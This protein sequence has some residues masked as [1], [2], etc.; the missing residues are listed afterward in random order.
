MS[1]RISFE[2]ELNE[3]QRT[4][5]DWQGE[6]LDL[7]VPNKDVNKDYERTVQQRK[8]AIRF[9][10]FST[11]LALIILKELPL[12]NS[13]KTIKPTT[14]SG[15]AGGEKFV[16]C[17][18]FFKLSR[19]WKNLYGGDSYAIK[20]ASHELK[21]AMAY[22]DCRIVGLHL[23]LIALIKFRGHAI[24]AQTLCPIGK[25]TIRYGSCD[26]VWTIHTDNPDLNQKME[27]A[28][29][30]INIKGHEV[31]SRGNGEFYFLHAPADVEGH[32]GTDGRFYLVDTAR[33]FPPAATKKGLP[34][35]K[36]SHLYQCLRPELVKLNPVPLSSDAF[37]KW[38]ASSSDQKLHNMEVKDATRR[39]EE[40]IIPAF[41]SYLD[42]EMWK[43]QHDRHHISNFLDQK[44]DISDNFL[45]QNNWK[46]SQLLLPNDHD[47]TPESTVAAPPMQMVQIVSDMHLHG[48]NTRYLGYLYT[49]L[50]VNEEMK[51]LVLTEA[52][53]R[54]LKHEMEERWRNINSL[55]DDDYTQALM[56]Y[57]T[58]V[59]G[60]SSDANQYWNSVVKQSLMVRFNP[61]AEFCS[62]NGQA[63]GANCSNSNNGANN[64]NANGPR[65]RRRSRPLHSENDPITKFLETLCQRLNIT[66]GSH[67]AEEF[68]NKCRHTIGTLCT[69][70]SHLR[71]LVNS[72]YWKAKRFYDDDGNNEFVK[73]LIE[74]MLNEH[75]GSGGVVIDLFARNENVISLGHEKFVIKNNI[76]LE[77]CYK[78]L[79]VLLKV[80]EENSE[81]P[82]HSLSGT[83][84]MYNAASIYDKD[85]LSTASGYFFQPLRVQNIK[86]IHPSVKHIHKISFEEGYA[87]NRLAM[88][89]TGKESKKIFQMARKKFEECLDIKENDHV[90]LYCLAFSFSQLALHSK[91]PKRDEFWTLSFEKYARLLV[92]QPNDVHALTEFG[93]SL[94]LCAQLTTDPE[95]KVRLAEKSCQKFELA[96]QLQPNFYRICFNAGNAYALYSK[97]INNEGDGA[98]VE[99]LLN[100]AIKFYEI[101]CDLAPDA[102]Q[103]LSNLALSLGRLAVATIDK[104]AQDVL[105][106]RSYVYFR[107]TITT[108]DSLKARMIWGHYQFRHAQLTKNSAKADSLFYSAAQKFHRVVIKT[109]DFQEERVLSKEY[110]IWS[111]SLSSLGKILEMCLKAPPDLSQESIVARGK[112]VFSF[113][114]FFLKIIK[115][116]YIENSI[117][118]PT[119]LAQVV[120]QF[121]INK[122][123]SFTSLALSVFQSISSKTNSRLLHGSSDKTVETFSQVLENPTHVPP[124]TNSDKSLSLINTREH[125]VMDWTSELLLQQRSDRDLAEK[126]IGA[127]STRE[128]FK[129][130]VK[131]TVTKTA[132]SSSLR[133]HHGAGIRRENSK[134]GKSDKKDKIH[135]ENEDK[136]TEEKR[137]KEAKNAAKLAKK[138][139]KER[140]KEERERER[141]SAQSEK[142]L[143]GHHYKTNEGRLEGRVTLVADAGIPS[144]DGKMQRRKSQQEL[145][146]SD[147][148]LEKKNSKNI[149]FDHLTR[150][151]LKA[152]L[153][154]PL[155]DEIEDAR[156][157]NFWVR[158][159]EKKDMADLPVNKTVKRASDNRPPQG[160]STGAA[161]SYALGTAT[162]SERVGSSNFGRA[163]E[164]HE[165]EN[166]HAHHVSNAMNAS[167]H[168]NSLPHMFY[169]PT[170]TSGS[171]ATH[172]LPSHSSGHHLSLSSAKT[173]TKESKDS[174]KQ[175]KIY[176]QEKDEPP[177]TSKSKKNAFR[178]RKTHSLNSMPDNVMN[179][180]KKDL[181]QAEQQKENRTLV[182]K[183]S[184]KLFA[185][186]EKNKQAE[187][188]LTT[189]ASNLDKHNKEKFSDK[190]KKIEQKKAIRK[191]I[192]LGPQRQSKP[193]EAQFVQI[194]YSFDEAKVEPNNFSLTG[195]MRNSGTDV[196]F[197]GERTEMQPTNCVIRLTNLHASASSSRSP[198]KSEYLNLHHPFLYKCMYVLSDEH[199]LYQIYEFRRGVGFYEYFLKV[200]GFKPYTSGNYHFSGSQ[201]SSST[202]QAPPNSKTPTA[203]KPNAAD[204]GGK[205]SSD[206]NA[207]P[208]QG[209]NSPAKSGGSD[210]RLSKGGNENEEMAGNS[211]PHTERELGGDSKTATT[212][213]CEVPVTA[214]I[215]TTIASASIPSQTASTGIAGVSANS[216]STTT[217]TTATNL[218]AALVSVNLNA[219]LTSNILNAPP[220]PN[221]PT[222]LSSRHSTRITAL[223]LPKS[224]SSERKIGFHAKL[225]KTAKPTH[226]SHSANAAMTLTNE[227]S[228]PN[229][230]PPRYVG[231]G[232]MDRPYLI[233]PDYGKSDGIDGLTDPGASGAWMSEKDDRP[234]DS[235]IGVHSIP[236]IM[237]NNVYPD[238]SGSLLGEC[239]DE[240]HSGDGLS[241]GSGMSSPHSL[242][243]ASNSRQALHRNRFPSRDTHEGN[244]GNEVGM[245]DRP[246]KVEYLKDPSTTSDRMNKLRSFSLS[247]DMTSK[248]D[249]ELDSDRA[250]TTHVQT[251]QSESDRKRSMM[252]KI[253]EQIY[254]Y[255]AQ[256]RFYFVEA[257]FLI[258]YLQ[259]TNFILQD[260]DPR[261]ILLTESGHLCWD[262]PFVNQTNLSP[263]VLYSNTD[264][265]FLPPEVMYPEKIIEKNVSID[266]TILWWNFSVFFFY[267]FYGKFPYS[268]AKNHFVFNYSKWPS[269]MSVMCSEFFQKMFALDVKHRFYSIAQLQTLPFF[270]NVDW[271]NVQISIK[272]GLVEKVFGSTV[273]SQREIDGY[274]ESFHTVEPDYIINNMSMSYAEISTDYFFDITGN[275]DSLQ[276]TVSSGLHTSHL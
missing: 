153:T 225:D 53:A 10:E 32:E 161:V 162:G 47:S 69:T 63:G 266:K 166:L 227:N 261:S 58:F 71:V 177:V 94:Y 165:K 173:D 200:Q 90:A 11:R 254:P 93:S 130:P 260:F 45:H 248:K 18:I 16:C 101:A 78:R 183:L 219:A 269:N 145:R 141:E 275:P 57:V 96:S 89:K 226:L 55:N 102:C 95:E 50:K 195:V 3:L 77:L 56:D 98:Q 215:S 147:A 212:V 4:Q 151:D 222:S 271:Q 238:T 137:D 82:E 41:A 129:E 202:Q 35:S 156:T 214:S 36:G 264:E 149:Q 73:A 60:D 26:Q 262:V 111:Q 168:T 259:S 24:L 39:L 123:N 185:N 114:E 152:G 175:K 196:V 5:I 48:I 228:K 267:V 75:A 217:T 108:K 142:N 22:L 9:A 112:I 70:V 65:G 273:P 72:V 253:M 125:P 263:R 103:A 87:L 136:K 120:R 243:A 139:A 146:T 252:S 28:A 160:V 140:D 144:K 138:D 74:S 44:V 31:Q 148:R 179:M 92:L 62:G 159:K 213:T 229:P 272:S 171:S 167:H 150:D 116:Y 265:M 216:A 270:A 247:N 21:G 2:N 169:N 178:N 52:V 59:F 66:R 49:L 30:I 207:S 106:E 43:S 189:A 42:K 158:Y 194:Y 164:S 192:L 117:E 107:R 205:D 240:G 80:Q 85:D 8:L 33:V 27:T 23:P 180:A 37:S 221:S 25:N 234:A 88:T 163:S 218:H 134:S 206:P 181:T 133:D 230:S 99:V 128:S 81:N 105:F 61:Y 126:D 239:G 54:V 209:N 203:G 172:S 84:D 231:F 274:V 220:V 249:P 1:E 104:E 256:L 118:I 67:E 197:L 132:S 46:Q 201:T 17:G 15:V 208:V 242:P 135:Q 204:S 232:F 113:A 184:G 250:H 170:G 12:P 97:C 91:Q 193:I 191:Q 255:E 124:L 154:V 233:S 38:G 211:S 127:L 76:S 51:V 268:I 34:A 236:R 119:D 187:K 7:S 199:L 190:E 186:V 244:D 251:E 210:E 237:L 224:N 100:K 110:S 121:V 257:A 258:E 109:S 19:D 198:R 86:K 241:F 155:G 174:K 64:T 122:N 245:D 83:D 223:S 276:R 115:S 20:A 79:L 176:F 157:N 131:P 14:L 13:E 143:S 188:E 6:F 40:V 235:R 182:K 246:K 29:K 68:T